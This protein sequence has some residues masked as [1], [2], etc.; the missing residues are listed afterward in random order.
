MSDRPILIV[1]DSRGALLENQLQSELI[2]LNYHFFWRKGLRLI[3]TG[4]AVTPLVLRLKPKL[5]YI[6]NG[7]CDITYIKTRNPWTAAMRNPSPQETVN[8]YMTAVDQLLSELYPLSAQV[9]HTIM[10]IFSTQVG[11][12]LGK[13]SGYPDELISPEQVYLNRAMLMINRRVFAL[14]RAMGIITQYLSSPVHTR[15][16]GKYRFVSGKLHDGCHPTYELCKEWASKI[17][18]NIL[19]NSERYPHYDFVNQIYN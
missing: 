9:G 14:N 5:I 19:S 7:I 12:D 3:H 17:K 13:Y 11:M 2:D 4:E 18:K 6:I 15:C 8:S 1:G 10:V 16:R